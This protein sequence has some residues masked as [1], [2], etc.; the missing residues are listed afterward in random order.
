MEVIIKKK[1][2][3]LAFNV[4]KRNDEINI[5]IKL[6]KQINYELQISLHINE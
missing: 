6:S 4:N 1:S 3:K 2:V 5:N